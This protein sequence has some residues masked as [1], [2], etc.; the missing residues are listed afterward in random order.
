MR[1]GR[2]TIL[3]WMNYHVRTFE[4]FLAVLV[5]MLHCI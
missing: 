1:V 2:G 4:I 5:T 3:G